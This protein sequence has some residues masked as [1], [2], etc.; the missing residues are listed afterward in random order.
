MNI[1]FL[2][3]D[4]KGKRE[5]SIAAENYLHLPRIGEGVIDNAQSYEVDG[6]IHNITIDSIVIV[7][8]PRPSNAFPFEFNF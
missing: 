4:L 6:V 1:K 2:F 8:I 5:R 3:Y 7:C